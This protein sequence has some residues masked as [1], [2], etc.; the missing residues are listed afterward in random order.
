MIPAQL[1]RAEQVWRRFIGMFVGEAVKRK[2]GESIP[3]EW[4]A[5]LGKLLPQHLERGMRRLVHSGRDTVPSLPAFVRLC[6]QLGDDPG[7]NSG[8]APRLP[9][10]GGVTLDEW[11]CMANLHLLAHLRREISRR[12][13]THGEPGMYCG[14][15]LPNA[16]G[17]SLEMR[18]CVAQLVDA[19]NAWAKDMREI[20]DSNNRV[21]SQIQRECWDDYIRAAEKRIRG[22][23]AERLAVGGVAA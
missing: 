18:W 8:E 6:E 12:G 22:Y 4:P 15:G 5:V 14:H 1:Q 20:A 19:K 13:R 10:A 11:G 2:Y 21:D 16:P 7:E 3:P 9:A 23:L 17:S